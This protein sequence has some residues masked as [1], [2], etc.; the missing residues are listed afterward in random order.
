MKTKDGFS[1]FEL[2]RLRWQS[3]GLLLFKPVF[4]TICS[5]SWINKRTTAKVL[6]GLVALEMMAGVA[7][8]QNTWIGTS[9]SNWF[10][11]SN[12]SFSRPPMAQETVLINT[13]SSAPTVIA[14]PGAV[15]SELTVTN[16]PPDSPTPGSLTIESAGIL[17]VGS[18]QTGVGGGS[19][20]VGS[21][22]TSLG[23]GTMTVTGG[24]NVT[25][26]AGIIAVNSG[27]VG[28]VTV[29]GAN[30]TWT[31]SGNLYVGFSGTGT[32]TIQSGGTVS[33]VDGEI[34][35]VSD[36]TGT[37]TVSGRN[38]T[39]TNTGTVFVG[40]NG[41]GELTIQNGGLVQAGGFGLFISNSRFGTGTLNI[42]AAPGSDPVAPGTLE[43]S[44]VTFGGSGTGV[45]NFNHTA[46][47]YMF[48]PTISGP[49]KVNVFSGT[50]ILTGN[51]TYSKGT[52]IEG[53]ILVAGTSTALGTGDV[54][55]NGGI[56]RTPS[57]SNGMPLT[58]NVGGNYTQ[59]A[60]G[61]WPL[62]LGALMVPSMIM[63]RLAAMLA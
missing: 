61:R 52:T 57:S 25:D 63:C 11:P 38:A 16:S 1:Q 60:G 40:D 59:A 29:S 55:L 41:T 5:H 54:F 15:A 50:T 56:L 39:W 10:S 8:A 53:G 37:V 35:T 31:N 17:N 48:T 13:S 4:K 21:T 3:T 7:F 49:G 9:G 22:S 20:T 34:G 6:A 26:S 2:L 18:S 28:T 45:I 27:E 12:W 33:D 46:T 51:N 14:Q 47:D 42:G 43:T 36:S 58:I 32:L 30:S 23:A 62:V 44:K 19:L 24:G